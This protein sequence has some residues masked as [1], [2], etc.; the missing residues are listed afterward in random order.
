MCS[1]NPKF[2]LHRGVGMS[3]VCL[4]SGSWP[5]RPTASWS[6]TVVCCRRMGCPR[7]AAPSAS[8]ACLSRSRWRPSNS[9][10][11]GS[12]WG[13]SCS[14]FWQGAKGWHP[15]FRIAWE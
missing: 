12:P 11:W 8:G 1:G 13:L 2:C 6:T 15:G 14:V 10:T 3:W 9:K 7:C 5:G 4:H